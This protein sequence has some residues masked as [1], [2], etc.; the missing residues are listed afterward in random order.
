MTQEQLTEV[1]ER[2][3]GEI[4]QIPPMYSALKVNGQK[5]VSY[6]HLP[7][8]SILELSRKLLDEK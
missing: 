5:P 4:M 6:T 2:F 7:D 1:L 8:E 3:R